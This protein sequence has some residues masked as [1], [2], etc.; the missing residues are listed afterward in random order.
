MNTT[1]TFKAKRN[2]LIVEFLGVLGAGVVLVFWKGA[3][4][5]P[6]LLVFL[7]GFLVYRLLLN[8]IAIK[9]V[10]LRSDGVEIVPLFP[11]LKPRR[12]KSDQLASYKSGALSGR[13]KSRPFVGFLMPKVG[14][15]EM[16]WASGTERFS[17][18]DQLLSNLL[19]PPEEQMVADREGAAKL[20]DTEPSGSRQGRDRVSLGE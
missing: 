4:V 15:M 1:R 7:V 2:Q 10:I 14:K 5:T 3:A 19:P 12:W 8:G 6:F 13:V 11:W 18:L 16:L 17:E 20:E 9:T